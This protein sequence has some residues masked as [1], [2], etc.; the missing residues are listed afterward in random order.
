MFVDDVQVRTITAK[1]IYQLFDLA[2]ESLREKGIE[3]FKEDIVM[4]GLKNSL[5]KKYSCLDVGLYKLNT[6]IGFAF[7]EFTKP[8][9]LEKPIATLDNIFI[10][11]DH[12]TAQ[13]YRKIIDSIL[14]TLAKLDIATIRTS[15]EWTLCNN[16]ETFKTAVSGLARP[17][18]IYDLE[19]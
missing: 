19:A 15:D 17:R 7:I 5:V 10:S 6:L 13:N 14:L 4:V 18:T 1:D 2:C 16:C 3:N 11:Q 9:Y 8:V 12:R